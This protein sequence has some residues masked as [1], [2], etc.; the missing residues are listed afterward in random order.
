MGGTEKVFDGASEEQRLRLA[1]ERGN[2]VQCF[3]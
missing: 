1:D 3:Q 2:M